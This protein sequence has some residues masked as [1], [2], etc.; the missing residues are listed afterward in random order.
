MCVDQGECEITI[1]R[2]VRA[3]TAKILVVHEMM[4]DLLRIVMYSKV[5]FLVFR[6]PNG[7]L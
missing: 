1:V 2:V 3:V 7:T 6:H 4:Y 5:G